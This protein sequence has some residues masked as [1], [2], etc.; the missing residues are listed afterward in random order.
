MDQQLK[1]LGIHVD[2]VPFAETSI[3]QTYCDLIVTTCFVSLLCDKLQGFTFNHDVNPI[4]PTPAHVNVYGSSHAKRKA[5]LDFL[6]TAA[7]AIRFSWGPG[8]S[9]CYRK[10][11]KLNGL[12]GRLERIILDHE[13][14]V[15]ALYVFSLGTNLLTESRSRIPKFKSSIYGMLYSLA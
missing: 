8:P 9:M 4:L 2:M 1:E 5:L 14:E 13:L 6:K 12:G 10:I 11:A 15:N 3:D 7:K